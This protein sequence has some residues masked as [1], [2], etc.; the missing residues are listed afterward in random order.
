MYKKLNINIIMNFPIEL[1][2]IIC[3]FSGNKCKKC[4]STIFK[5]Y[6]HFESVYYC[7]KKCFPYKNGDLIILKFI[8][9][10]TI[11]NIYYPAIVIKNQNNF[12]IIYNDSN[13][14]RNTKL[15]FYDLNYK[16]YILNQS[17]DFLFYYQEFNFNSDTIAIILFNDCIYPSKIIEL[18]KNKKNVKVLWNN[19]Y[20]NIISSK[21][22]QFK[23]YYNLPTNHKQIF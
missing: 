15:Q 3:E 6:F 11:N 4:G 10:I 20:K 18:N 12:K 2:K 14:I 5:P 17:V 8:E 22:S 19:I 13:N 21:I 9:N 7:C 1:V 16:F 23:V